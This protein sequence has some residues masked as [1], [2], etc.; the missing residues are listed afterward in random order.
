M[1]SFSTGQQEFNMKKIAMSLFAVTMIAAGAAQAEVKIMGD[2][3]QTVKAEFGAVIVNVAKGSGAKAKQNLASN[4]GK[5]YIN[6]NNKQLV[7]L[8]KG[9]LVANVAWGD[10]TVATQNLASNT[11]AVD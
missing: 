8:G 11:S 9:G 4:A 2:N 6:G 1:G 7:D 5:V 10:N 3:E